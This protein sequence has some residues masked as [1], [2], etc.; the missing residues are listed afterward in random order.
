MQQMVRDINNLRW[1][2]PA[3]RSPAG[4]VT[5]VDN[6]NPIV[7][8]RRFNFDGDLILI[9][10]NASD[11]QWSA[12][13]YAVNIAGESGIWKEIFNSQAP[14]YGGVGTVG[15]YAASLAVSN[16]QLWINLPS[17]SVLLFQ[18]Q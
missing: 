9:V 13:D 1:A 2:H 6:Q 12:N 7:G 8:F 17:W 3:L 16:G 18:K 5:H 11:A 15:N 4:S 10:V 14:V